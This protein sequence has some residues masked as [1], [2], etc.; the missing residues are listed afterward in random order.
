MIPPEL[1]TGPALD[2]VCEF[3]EH[4]TPLTDPDGGV[5]WD[6]ILEHRGHG[7][8]HGL[9]RA[10]V[11][12]EKIRPWLVYDLL[13]HSI[14]GPTLAVS[15]KMLEPII[16]WMRD[17]C[18]ATRQNC[19]TFQFDRIPEGDYYP[20][21]IITECVYNMVFFNLNMLKEHAGRAVGY[22]VAT[23][24]KPTA[25][26]AIKLSRRYS[27]LCSLTQYLPPVRLML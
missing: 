18:L 1:L 5:L 15:P 12:S 24:E 19:R 26:H 11:P 20:R 27:L 2:A 14:V 21:G 13:E 25:W 6:S 7:Y 3:I 9:P 10:Y 22:S 17:P 23:H 16:S 8:R 4:K